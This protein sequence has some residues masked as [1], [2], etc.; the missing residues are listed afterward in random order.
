[1]NKRAYL[2]A[3]TAILLFAFGLRILGTTAHSI[4]FDEAME[5]FTASA[6]LSI[7]SEAV[8]ANN[9]QPPLFGLLLHL[10]LRAGL[11]PIW[12]R[13]LPLVFSMLTVAG[14][15]SWSARL[16]GRRGAILA[17]LIIAVMP[18]EAYYAQDVGEYALLV[19]AV[20]WS[21][22]FLDMARRTP[23]WRFWLLWALFSLAGVYTH[24]GAA[25]VIVP[26]ALMVLVENLRIGRR[27]AVKRELL[28]IC[29]SIFAVL[30]LLLLFL[31]DQIRN[32]EQSL[33]AVTPVTTLAGELPILISSLDDVFLY[34][35]VG[36]PISTIPTW[37]ATVLLAGAL[38]LIILLRP[39]LPGLL[40][41]W[42]AVAYI[43]HFILVRTGLYVGAFGF[44]YGLILTPLF[45]LLL[46]AIIDELF[47]RRWS[48]LGWAALISIMALELYALPTPVPFKVLPGQQIW[49]PQEAMAELFDYW[50]EHRHAGETTF[51][52]YGAVPAFRY[53]L[54]LND[55]DPER[56][57]SQARANV[58]CSAGQA[59]EVCKANNLFYGPWVRRLSPDEKVRNMEEVMGG[60]PDR[61]WLLF[62]HVHETEKED[63]MR[64]LEE[65]YRIERSYQPGAQKPALYLLV[66]LGEEGAA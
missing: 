37:P 10:W 18:T 12:Q 66:R 13:F 41:A 61:L 22:Y 64:L 2:T 16:F 55:L 27:D 59:Q 9:Y 7:L 25:I 44:R 56:V 31:P 62:S 38:I 33:D 6:P 17:G 1:M 19:F 60:R 34:N 21:L 45:V 52:Y 57:S 36:W 39:R 58:K 3:S 15:M 29:L 28:T 5:Y 49:V 32:V 20:T 54:R 40:Y 23:A 48:L 53:Y 14:L 43:G 4:W 35:L 47:R 30:P 50:Q 63:M 42:F 11:E 24:Y 51:V 26:A 46:V 8:T 65:D